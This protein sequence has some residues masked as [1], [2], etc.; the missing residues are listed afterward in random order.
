[1]TSKVKEACDRAVKET[2]GNREAAFALVR[3]WADQDAALREEIA[4]MAVD[5]FLRETIDEVLRDGFSLDDPDAL[6]EEVVRRT[7]RRHLRPVR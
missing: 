1:M 6:V 7:R 5:Q 4:R 2:G 3:K